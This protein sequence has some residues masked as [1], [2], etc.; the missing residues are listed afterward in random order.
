MLSFFIGTAVADF[1]EVAMT[2]AATAMTGTI[3]KEIRFTIKFS[4]RG[5]I[6]LRTREPALFRGVPAGFQLGRT[7]CP[8]NPPSVIPSCLLRFRMKKFGNRK[9]FGR[10]DVFTERLGIHH[11]DIAAI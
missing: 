5:R 6:I 10:I 9:S 7:P 4:L 11:D 3:A 8:A 1:S 2:A